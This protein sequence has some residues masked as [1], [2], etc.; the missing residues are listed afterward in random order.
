MLFTSQSR[1]NRLNPRAYSSPDG[2]PKN[3]TD[4]FQL[5][6]NEG[7]YIT[8]IGVSTFPY[9]GSPTYPVAPVEWVQEELMPAL[10][11]CLVPQPLAQH[12]GQRS[13]KA[14]PGRENRDAKAYAG[15]SVYLALRYGTEISTFEDGVRFYEMQLE[16]SS[17][18]DATDVSTWSS[19]DERIFCTC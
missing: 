5:R 14:T 6:D 11:Y 8:A 16:G 2:T 9:I 15:L 1:I 17:V 3:N 12:L 7:V 19:S 4:F 13:K 10:Y 18:A